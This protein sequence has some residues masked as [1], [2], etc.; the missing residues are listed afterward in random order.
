[1]QHVRIMLSAVLLLAASSV[2]GAAQQAPAAPA[3]PRAH[4]AE[5]YGMHR[6]SALVG[7]RGAL[8]PRLSRA[9]ADRPRLPQPALALPARLGAAVVAGGFGQVIAPSRRLLR[10]PIHGYGRHDHI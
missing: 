4:C 3:D 10:T 6:V 5:H 7:G 9:F 8:E 1:M 2:P